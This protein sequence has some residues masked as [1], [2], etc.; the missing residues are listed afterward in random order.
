MTTFSLKLAAMVCM[1]IDHTAILLLAKGLVDRETYILMRTIGR[2]AFPIYCFLLAE[3]FRRLRGEPDRLRRHLALLVLLA[4]VS[5][6]F[7]DYFDHGSVYYPAGQSVIF[8]L[9]LGFGG[10]WLAESYRDRPLLRMG[11]LAMTATLGYYI[12]SDYRVAGVALVFLCFFYLERFEAWGP[13]GRLLGMLGVVGFYYLFYCWVAGGFGGPAAIWDRLQRMGVY[14]IPHLILIPIL[15][16]YRGKLGY[17]NRVLHRCYQWFYP[18]HL[19]VLAG[20]AFL[21]RQP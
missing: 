16:T 20:I 21:T 13:G 17:R 10:L 9:L 18:A 19:A 7:F 2:F 6:P 4:L 8:T 5:E 11:V 1:L 3:G 15:A 14:G 12:A